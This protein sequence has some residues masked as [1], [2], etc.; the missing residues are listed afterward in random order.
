MQCHINSLPRCAGV[1]VE[2]AAKRI[3]RRGRICIQ[4]RIA[5]PGLA[6]FANGQVL[7]FVARVTEPHFPVPR[8]EVIAN[9]SHLTAQANVEQLVPVSGVFVPYARIVDGAEANSRSQRN[10]L[11][12]NNQCRVSNSEWIE[13][14][15]D[16]HTDTEGAA[17]PYGR[18]RRSVNTVEPV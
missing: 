10:R 13:R 11:P 14:I 17:R 18:K 16:R 8:L 15:L 4:Q 7:S 9:L 12:V 2:K 1:L 5:Q 6:R 3:K